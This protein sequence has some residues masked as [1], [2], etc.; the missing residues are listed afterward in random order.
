VSKYND[1]FDEELR[2]V[3]R[4]DLIPEPIPAVDSDIWDDLKSHDLIGDVAK[5][6]KAYGHVYK[7]GAHLDEK[8][9][10]M[11]KN[12]IEEEIE[13]TAEGLG[14]I[15]DEWQRSFHPVDPILLA[16][17]LVDTIVVCLG[18]LIE[19]FGEG[20]ARD[21][22]LEVQRS[23]ESKISPDGSVVKREDGKVIKGPNY[24]PPDVEG[25]LK[26]H[27]ILKEVAT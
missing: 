2:R 27:G 23:N 10:E 24:S 8:V 13:E 19:L 6:C 26:K 16:D 22:W 21:L 14:W 3:P 18:G 11:R 4:R 17:G 20:C 5:I 7:P 25:I 15:T 1:E 12:L 9:V